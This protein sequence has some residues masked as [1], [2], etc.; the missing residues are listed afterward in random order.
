MPQFQVLS[1][2]LCLSAGISRWKTSRRKSVRWW[3]HSSKRI[4]ISSMSNKEQMAVQGNLRAYSDPPLIVRYGLISNRN[5]A[6]RHDY[7]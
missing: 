5:V 3:Q 4:L 7:S 6:T 1:Y 2:I